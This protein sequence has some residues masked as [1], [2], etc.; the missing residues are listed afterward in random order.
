[1]T[2]K[3]NMSSGAAAESVYFAQRRTFVMGD[4]KCPSCG[5][6]SCTGGCYGNDGSAFMSEAQQS[7][8]EDSDDRRVI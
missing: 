1:M 8:A 6:R 5:E 7:M 4:G 3:A 2:I